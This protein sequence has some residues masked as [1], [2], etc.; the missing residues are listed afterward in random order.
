[1]VLEKN[2][3]FFGENWQQSLKIVIIT[4]TPGGKKYDLGKRLRVSTPENETLDWIVQSW[5]LG[6][7]YTPRVVILYS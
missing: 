5:E 2:A 1:M 4:S 7:K 6:M 3:N